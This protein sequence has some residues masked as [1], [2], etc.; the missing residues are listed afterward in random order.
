MEDYDKTTDCEVYSIHVKVDDISTKAK[1][2]I[3][4]IQDTSWITE[5]D[6]IER[7]SFDARAQ[8]TIDKL[9]HEILS[10]VTTTLSDDFGEFLISVTAQ[11]SLE[12]QY[13]HT[14]V[15]LA[16]L[17]KE[18]KSGNPG[19]DFHTETSTQLLAYGEAKYSGSINPYTK[20]LKQIKGFLDESKDKMELTD[21]KYFTSEESISSAL[22]DKKAF[23]AAFSINSENP[24]DIIENALSSEH[25]EDLLDYEELYII[26]IEVDA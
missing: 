20:A 26:G 16:E 4:M 22:E 3:I 6:I 23:V 11:D 14:K 1:Q 18:K 25:I 15:P 17:F 9:V 8:P 13:N 19:F 2:M 21:L 12:L 24:S 5:L 10:K 7:A